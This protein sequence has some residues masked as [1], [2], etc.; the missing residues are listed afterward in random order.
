MIVLMKSKS[1]PKKKPFVVKPVLV[2]TLTVQKKTVKYQIKSQ[3]EVTPKIDSML[4]SQVTG[5]II[6]TSEKFIVG[7]YFKKGE[8]L[9]NVDPAEYKISVAQAKARLA[10]DKARLAQEKARVKQAEKEWGLTGRAKKDAPALAL[11]IP[12]LKEA[13]AN[14]DA[15]Q[16]ELD[17][18]LLKLKR[19]QI[20][21]PFNGMIKTKSANLGQFVNAGSQIAQFFATD[22]AQVRLPLT[23]K[24]LSFINLPKT[25]TQDAKKVRVAFSV[26]SGNQLVKRVG[27]IHH[28]EGVVDTRSR[29]HYAVAQINDPYN[30]KGDKD[31]SAIE[32]GS[33]VNAN[34][35]GI[36]AE[37]IISIPRSSVKG[38]RTVM[39]MSP[40]NKLTRKIITIQRA[41]G[42]TV[43]VSSGLNDKD[44]VIITS[45]ETP[46][47][48]MALTD[49][50]VDESKQQTKIVSKVAKKESITDSETTK[51]RPQLQS[52]L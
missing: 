50:K 13:Q 2:K 31:L 48:G 27:F 19:T 40:S 42:D 16:A 18:A 35:E 1:L 41:Q 47:E 15:S 45:L 39:V 49:K 25:A 30:L 38:N 20:V 29:M 12:N 26:R 44:K 43:F 6:S 3:G 36:E 8:V 32:I 23:E 10:G 46:V 24:N 34:I 37:N 51:R 28:M 52:N 9:L 21:A 5:P 7:G 14:V 22:I 4:V 33:F 17:K 11:R